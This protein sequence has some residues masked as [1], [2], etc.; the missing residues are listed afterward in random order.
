MKNL[1][2]ALI[3][4]LYASFVMWVFTTTRSFESLIVFG[5][6]ASPVILLA[7]WVQGKK[8]EQKRYDETSQY[9][10]LSLLLALASSI[11]MVYFV[12]Q[13]VQKSDMVQFFGAYIL[14]WKIDEALIMLGL[15]IAMAA[16]GAVMWTTYR[17]RSSKSPFIR[18]EAP[19]VFFAGAPEKTRL[20]IY[21]YVFAFL[22]S[23]AV[24]VQSA[25]WHSWIIDSIMIIRLSR[26]AIPLA[27]FLVIALM[28]LPLMGIAALISTGG[29]WYVVAQNYTFLRAS[30]FIAIPVAIVVIYVV[31]SS[32]AVSAAT[33]KKTFSTGTAQTALEAVVN[34]SAA[35]AASGENGNTEGES[36]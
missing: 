14:G 25:L 16:S 20:G 23:V 12:M 33:E 13:F 11:T 27:L 1:S 28:R 15:S 2:F 5:T 18:Y 17:F 6:A 31:I 4:A 3:S 32:M 30:V 35:D 10:W 7:M 24:A 8:L 21:L 34:E 36:A 26:A 29:A 22:W 9:P 19:Y